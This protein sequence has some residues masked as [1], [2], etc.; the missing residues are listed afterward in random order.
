MP[1]SRRGAPATVAVLAL[2]AVLATTACAPWRPGETAPGG[3]P[4]DGDPAAARARQ[5][6]VVEVPRLNGWQP[7][8][9]PSADPATALGQLRAQH[10]PV[11]TPD[12]DWA[13]PPQVCGTAWELDGIAGPAADAELAVLGD[14]A[15]AAALAV[16]RYEHQLSRALADPTPLA[17]L[18]VATAAVDPAR[19][20]ILAL[21]ASHIRDGTR[22]PSPASHPDEV[23][24][25]GASESS[26]VAVACT[27]A[28]GA[29]PAA[30]PAA[31]PA[32]LQAYLLTA[33]RGLEDQ[34][35]DIS[36]RVS[37]T[38]HRSA[39]GCASLAAWA[40]EWR[41]HIQAWIVEGQLWEQLGLT[42]TAEGIC[43][44]LLVD[45]PRECPRQWPQ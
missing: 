7:F 15:T 12:L 26:V 22:S 32:R 43:A 10:L 42:L 19:S 4:A 36:Y 24:L 1:G 6:L 30:E 13:F 2:V 33:S 35:V 23:V 40:D 20:Q 25:V 11:W 3:D 37:N 16:M 39:K 41:D 5:D 8:L 29:V 44:S 18:C 17:Q 27:P 31:R 28:A 21:V 34:V 14:F 38:T 9:D 45:G